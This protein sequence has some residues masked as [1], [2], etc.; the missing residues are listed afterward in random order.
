M[1]IGISGRKQS[2][3]STTSNFLLSL[4]MAKMNL[5]T[6]LELNN[7]GHIIVSDLLGQTQYSGLLDYSSIIDS[8]DYV[9]KQIINSLNSV[10]K[11]YSFADPLKK[12]ICMNMLGLTYDQCYGSD[13]HKNTSTDIY[14]ENK[15]L[16]AREV[17]EVVGTKIFRKLKNDVWVRA[18][19]SKI[20]K[21]NPTIA[22]IPDCRFPNE[23]DA[24]H[25][26]GGK[27]IRLT[28]DP[29][30]SDAEAEAALDKEKYDWSNFDY[31]CDNK[32]MSIYE[33]CIDI[34][35]QLQEILPL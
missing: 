34:R 33:Q 18:T 22:I 6:N 24:I 32:N 35:N 17:M 10:C 7:S 9:H 3:K 30:G 28:R 16:S 25:A 2:G 31:V 13:E 12:D 4:F 11:L 1:I 15:Q 20:E 21:D 5:C 14:W 27:V 8:P 23:I 29:F 26:C 19:I